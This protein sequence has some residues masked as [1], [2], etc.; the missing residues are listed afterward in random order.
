W[1]AITIATCRLTTWGLRTSINGCSCSLTIGVCRPAIAIAARQSAFADL[2]SRLQPD[3]WRLQ[4]CNPRLQPDNWRLQ[5]C[6]PRL[7][8]DNWRLQTC[9][10]DCGASP[11]LSPGVTGY[12]NSLQEFLMSSEPVMESRTPPP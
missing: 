2:Q 3:N 6:N 4:T 5:T 12:F 9:N 8:P 1:A 11:I 10:R 7:Q